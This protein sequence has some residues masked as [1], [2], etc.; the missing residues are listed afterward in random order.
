MIRSNRRAVRPA[1]RASAALQTRLRAGFTL[2]EML[3]VMAVIVTLAAIALVVVPGILDQDRTTDAA[4][5]TRQWLTIAKVRAG[6]DGLPRGVRLIVALDPNNPA[7]TDPRFV[8][9]LQY[10]ESPPV[11][12]PNTNM[13]TDVVNAP[14]V[15]FFYVTA[16]ASGSGTPTNPVVGTGQLTAQYCQIRNLTYDEA[17]QVIPNSVIALPTIGTWHRIVPLSAGGFPFVIDQRNPPPG[18]P[19]PNPPVSTSGP[20]TFTVQ[21]GGAAAPQ[22][23]L[24]PWPDGVLGAGSSAPPPPPPPGQPQFAPVPTFVSYHFGIY[25]A[26]RP[27]LGEPLLQLPKNVCIDLSVSNPPAPAVPNTSPPVYTDYDIVFAPSGQVLSSFSAAG[28]SGQINLWVR[29]YTKVASMLPTVTP[30]NPPV[31]SIAAFQ[32]GGEQQIVALKTRSGSLG[33]FPVYWPS[34]TT[35]IYAPGESP[36]LFA[37]K[38]ANGP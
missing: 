36:Y 15:V 17:I 21:I 29:D 14:Q 33:V 3:V 34:M 5:L 38:G 37:I 30:P 19:V 35:G 9:E 25:G 27:L 12:V 24:D 8:T 1:R 32:N 6:R 10:T 20:R 28:G 18:T 16:N 31:W 4:G 13:V 22:V 11:L 2:I 7:K 23:Y 26:P